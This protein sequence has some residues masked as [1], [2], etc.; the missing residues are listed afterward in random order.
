MSWREFGN[1]MLVATGIFSAVFVVMYGLAAPW[2]RSSMG[3]ALFAVLFSLAGGIAYFVWSV[4][5]SPLPAGFYPMR[6]LIFTAMAV[7]IGSSVILFARAQVTGHPKRKKV[8]HGLEDA[9]E[10]NRYGPR[11][12]SDGGSDGVPRSGG[13]RGDAE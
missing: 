13:G 10:G 4:H 7:S 2:Y 6:A 5:H 8:R 12:R 11:G 9:W 3:K 1:W